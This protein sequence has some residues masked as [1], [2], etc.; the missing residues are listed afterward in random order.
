MKNRPWLLILSLWLAVLACTG[1]PSAMQIL[2]QP[3]YACP[4]ATPRP[5]DTPLPTSVQPNVIVPPS[6]WATL[7]LVPGCLWNGRVC[8]TNTPVFGGI[9]LTPAATRPGATSTPRPTTTPYPTATAFVMRPPQEFFVG[10]AIYTGGFI[11][12]INIRL[13]LL[14][15]VT[16]PRAL[17]SLP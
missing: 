11:S 10:D 2:D 1:T 5:T 17:Q 6:D 12:T 3:V 9:Y 14:N 8:A 16:L 4:T 7:T 15:S 13:R